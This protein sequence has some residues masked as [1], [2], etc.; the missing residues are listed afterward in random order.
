MTTAPLAYTYFCD[1][2]RK[3]D[4]EDFLLH[5]ARRASTQPEFGFADEWRNDNPTPWAL[6]AMARDI[7]RFGNPYRSKKASA[8]DF[9]RLT[10]IFNEC[11]EEATELQPI[12][13]RI[14]AYFYEQFKYQVDPRSGLIRQYL[15]LSRKVDEGN[16]PQLD[17]WPEV[18][19]CSLLEALDGAFILYV[20][21]RATGGVLTSTLL[22]G[23]EFAKLKTVVPEEAFFQ[24]LKRLTATRLEMKRADELTPADGHA[25]RFRFNPLT[26]TPLIQVSDSTL[27]CPQPRLILEAVSLEGLYYA[28]IKHWGPGFAVHLGYLFEDYVGHQLRH[29][30]KLNV[31]AEITWGP[32]KARSQSVDWIVE[33]NDAVLLIE[34]K[35]ARMTLGA[36]AGGTEAAIGAYEKYISKASEQIDV[37]GQEIASGNPDFAGIDPDRRRIGLIVTAEPF[38]A[39]NLPEVRD[40]L[41][42]RKTP[43]LTISISDL[44]ILSEL[45]PERLSA[46]L[47]AIVDD[48]EL[49]GSLFQ[50]ALSKAAGDIPLPYNSI[51]DE[52][53]EKHFLSAL[54]TNSSVGDD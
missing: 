29:T 21:A 42:A 45:E 8:N 52:A 28:G 6:A 17:D 47:I 35:S 44:E 11:Y 31:R 7:I 18:L 24:T 54:P 5:V 4:Q 13:I 1:E 48:P 33:T 22:T 46:I 15:I 14:V 26:A 43:F 3:F 30:G 50:G 25:H 10:R 41:P 37:S 39:A 27:V 19:G 20:A 40:R 12:D 53:L 9:T 16:K 23:D 36:R 34:C 32:K 49:Y 38:Y 2:I 51:I